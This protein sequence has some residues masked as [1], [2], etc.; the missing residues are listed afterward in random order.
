MVIVILVDAVKTKKTIGF[1]GLLYADGFDGAIVV[2][3]SLR[4]FFGVLIHFDFQKYIMRIFV[5]VPCLQK[6]ILSQYF[7][8]LYWSLS[9]AFFLYLTFLYVNFK[10]IKWE[11]KASMML[12]FLG[13]VGNGNVKKRWQNIKNIHKAGELSLSK[14]FTLWISSFLLT[15]TLIL[16]SRKYEKAK[17]K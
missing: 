4:A 11:W 12:W 16:R 8:T 14:F 17:T 9:A 7:N 3:A 15:F 2:L 5:A 1:A 6:C 10:L 13:S